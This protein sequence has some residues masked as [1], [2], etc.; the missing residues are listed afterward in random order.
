MQDDIS[1]EG[2]NFLNI[3]TA[4]CAQEII[5]KIRENGKTKEISFNDIKESFKYLYTCINKNNQWVSNPIT[6]ETIKFLK[7]L[8]IDEDIFGNFLN[9]FNEAKRASL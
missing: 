6:R 5:D 7:S 2:L 4:R 9:L 8:N 1:N 3:E